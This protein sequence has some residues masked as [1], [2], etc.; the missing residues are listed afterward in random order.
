MT[1]DLRIEEPPRRPK[2][3][4]HLCSIRWQKNLAEP[5]HTC[6]YKA[7]IHGDEKTLCDCCDACRQECAD[8]V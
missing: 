6:P 5:L 7:D 4:G 3:S 2:C 8:N 1:D